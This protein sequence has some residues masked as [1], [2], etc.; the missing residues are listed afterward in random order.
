MIIY[1]AGKY[2]G[3]IWKNIYDARHVAI[4]LW[5]KGYTVICPHLNTANFEIDCMCEY[6]DYIKGYLAI[7]AR[8]DAVVMLPGWE[9]SYGATQERNHAQG[10]GIEVFEYPTLPPIAVPVR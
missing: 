8:C 5:Q 1:L 10:L 9:D 6:E 7:I 3:D 2:S 4:E